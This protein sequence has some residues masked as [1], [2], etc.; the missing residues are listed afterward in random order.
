[1][2]ILLLLILFNKMKSMEQAMV[3]IYLDN[4]RFNLSIQGSIQ[5]CVTVHLELGIQIIGN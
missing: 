5:L 2:F 1:M 4:I 3:P